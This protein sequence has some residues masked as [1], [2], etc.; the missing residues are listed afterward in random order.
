MYGDQYDD[1]YGG[2]HDGDSDD[3]GPIDHSDDFKERHSGCTDIPCCC[4]FLIA[5]AALG[6]VT[7]YGFANGDPRKLHH[8]IDY[9][10]NICGVTPG[11]ELSPYIFYCAPGGA[12]GQLIGGSQATA[13]TLAGITLASGVCVEACPVLQSAVN[14][15]VTVADTYVPAAIPQCA[16]AGGDTK[17]YDTKTAFGICVPSEIHKNAGAAIS[18]GTST[19]Q[20]R[21]IKGVD[22]AQKGL[23]VY[24]LIFFVAIALGYLY[25]CFLKACA[26]CMV[27]LSIIV[28]FLV[29][30]S[31]GVWMIWEAQTI[32]TNQALESFGQFSTS[33]AYA[34]GSIFL[35]V[36]FGTLCLVCCCGHQIGDAIAAVQMTCDVMVAMPTL[37]LGPV[38]QAILKI[39]TIMMLLYGF[40]YLMST[41]DVQPLTDSGGVAG[42]FRQFDWTSEEKWMMF[43]YIFMAFWL[44]C[45]TTALYQ[46]AMSYATADYY[47]SVPYGGDERDPSPGAVFEGYCV[48]ALHHSGSLAFG[49]FII[50]VFA[51]IQRALEYIDKSNPNNPIV[52]CIVCIFWCMCTCF[53]QCAEFIN[54]NAYISMALTGRG[55][56]SSAMKAL[57]VIGQKAGAIFILAQASYFFQILGILLITSLCGLIAHLFIQLPMFTEEASSSF[58]PN[59]IIVV[60]ISA[61]V[62]LAMSKIF[63]D[64][65][66]MVSSTLVFCFAVDGNPNRVPDSVKLA[67]DE[68]NNNMHERGEPQ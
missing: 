12:V 53:K 55:F 27:W 30:L 49:S 52:R 36:A 54:K 11:T 19:W 24:V 51:M 6:V 28:I 58:L 43:F 5:L 44:L 63:M 32:G 35:L 16:A 39:V 2:E 37:L 15:G 22:S 48:G 18:E 33:V 8:G 45:F 40:I 9:N 57:S 67:V 47:Y 23:W 66:D 41:A 21:I 65:L 59:P 4:V 42:Q 34:I 25:M 46:F 20:A 13:G 62:G 50:A 56:C 68:V 1:H 26:S 14:T 10:G 17:P 7:G 31:I 64:V 3:E 60:V 61:L 29:S 38:V